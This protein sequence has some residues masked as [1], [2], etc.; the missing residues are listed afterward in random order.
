MSKIKI[1]TTVVLVAV[2]AS[3]LFFAC[4][5]D[6]LPIPESSIPMKKLK[7]FDGNMKYESNWYAYDPYSVKNN[8]LDLTYTFNNWAKW[9]DNS[10]GRFRIWRISP[11]SGTNKVSR[12]R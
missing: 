8:P 9:H 4:K 1:F 12:R 2:T 11:N 3:I 5:K 6:V 7:S 10:N